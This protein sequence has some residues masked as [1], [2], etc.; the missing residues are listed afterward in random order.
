MRDYEG[1][2]KSANNA[3]LEKLKEN[4]HKPGFNELSFKRALLGICRETAELSEEIKSQESLH[5]IRRE[6]A[7]VANFA[8]MIIYKCDKLISEMKRIKG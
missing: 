3:M 1:L 5:Y 7:D 6:A 4:E 8:A 2:I